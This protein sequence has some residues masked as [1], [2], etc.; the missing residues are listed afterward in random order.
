MDWIILYKREALDSGVGPF[1]GM[2]RRGVYMCIA[3]ESTYVRKLEESKRKERRE[4][5]I[6]IIEN[7]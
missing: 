6:E 7:G 5:H 4:E 1:G 2:W 3:L